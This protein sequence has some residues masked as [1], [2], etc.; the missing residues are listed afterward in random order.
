MP[1]NHFANSVPSARLAIEE[2][3][4]QTAWD[5]SQEAVYVMF[6]DMMSFVLRY[7]VDQSHLFVFSRNLR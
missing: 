4:I 6:N 7:M 1:Q 3:T 2:I 5:G